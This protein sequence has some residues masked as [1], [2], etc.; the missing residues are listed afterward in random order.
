MPGSQSGVLGVGREDFKV[1]LELLQMTDSFYWEKAEEE[2]K[3]NEY[4][5]SGSMSCTGVVLWNL[6]IKENQENYWKWE[7]MGKKMGY[8]MSSFRTERP[9]TLITELI[10]CIWIVFTIRKK[11]RKVWTICGTCALFKDAARGKKRA[12][13]YAYDLSGKVVTGM[14]VNSRNESKTHMGHMPFWED[15]KTGGMTSR[16]VIRISLVKS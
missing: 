16:H 1:Q 10:F 13:S 9:T 15:I 11:G 8:K 7:V 6:W 14:R 4:Q 2:M 5:M 3:L 12:L